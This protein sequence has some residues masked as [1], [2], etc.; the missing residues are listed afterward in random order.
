MNKETEA[1]GFITRQS[2]LKQTECKVCANCKHRKH[3]DILRRY[4]CLVGHLIDVA[5]W[6]MKYEVCDKWEQEE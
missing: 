3:D 1:D 6:R 5:D 2:D 4:R